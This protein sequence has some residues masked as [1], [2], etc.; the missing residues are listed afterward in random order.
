MRAL[1]ISRPVA[2]FLGEP[3][4][5]TVVATFPRSCYLDLAGR[6]A[7]VV[8][9]EL[10]NGPLNVV[11]S[12]PSGFSFE[13]ISVGAP[14]STVAHTL[15]I[16]NAAEIDFAAAEVWDPTV[17]PLPTVSGNTL[18]TNLHLLE[19]IL[20]EEAPPE[21]LARLD[22]APARAAN[23]LAAL[24]DG[25]RRRDAGMVADAAGRLA[26]LGPGLTPSG[27]DVLAGALVALAV[28]PPADADVLRERMV[29]AVAGRT[30]RISLAYLD[31][32]ARGEAGETWHRLLALLPE[33]SPAGLLPAVRRV[34]AF[35][36]TSGADMLMGF[37]L[38]MQA[39]A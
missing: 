29:S 20:R 39:L 32:A 26:G 27:D 33:D 8:A 1:S 16:D 23:A 22:H 7:A 9:P 11:V 37:I 14:V 24:K 15:M 3:R 4:T 21:S 19:E 31:A 6:I 35:G 28:R 17:W 2:A 18:W 13:G 10:L 25:L 12:P 38:G 30:T 34:M 5:G 36:E